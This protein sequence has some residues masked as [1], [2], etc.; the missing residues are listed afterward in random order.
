MGASISAGYGLEDKTR[1]EAAVTPAVTTARLAG[2][3]KGDVGWPDLSAVLLG[4]FSPDP[5]GYKR[6]SSFSPTETLAKKYFNAPTITN[7]AEI[8][9][10]MPYEA[11]AHK[12]LEAAQEGTI[13]GGLGL[14]NELRDA[15][16]LVSIDGFYWPA[17]RQ[18]GVC[19]GVVASLTSLLDYAKNNHKP[20]VL[21]NIPVEDT[22]DVD[23]SFKQAATWSSPDPDCL[24]NLN[25]ALTTH[26]TT[27]HQCY[28]IDM[29]EMMENLKG[30]GVS[31]EGFMNRVRDFRFDG[32]HLSE[33]GT[34]YIADQIEKAMDAHPPDCAGAAAGAPTASSGG[35]STAG[36]ETAGES[37]AYQCALEKPFIMGASIS[38]GYGTE[39]RDRVRDSVVTAA[40]EGLSESPP[41]VNKSDSGFIPLFIKAIRS[42]FPGN[43][44][45]K[46]RAP[47]VRLAENYFDPPD[48]TNIAEILTVLPGGYGSYAYRQFDNALSD[49][50]E[51]G[52]A[53]KLK[54]STLLV[55]LDGFYWPAI[56]E[57]GACPD[58]VAGVKRIITYGHT[59]RKPL[60]LGNVPDEEEASVDAE[61]VETGWAPPGAAC[62]TAINN[63][64][65]ASCTLGNKCYLIDVHGMVEQ[66]KNT[67]AG[68]SFEGATHRVRDFRFDGVHLSAKG[69][70]Y[71]MR[72]ID[73]ALKAHPPDCASSAS[74][75]SSAQF[76]QFCFLFYGLNRPFCFSLSLHF[77]LKEGHKAP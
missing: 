62:L 77:F 55:S 5:A 61:L 70:R 64:L 30:V 8:I 16:L 19:P 23:E 54:G 22:A 56:R 6:G 49:T 40:L 66:L 11:F 50:T 71:F 39:E 69:L 37:T 41:I 48:I 35:S 25:T 1:V 47:T 60:L 68:I 28:L 53:E 12:Q 20:L 24:E 44:L 57:S 59:N 51:G 18:T 13:G 7:I 43:R 73:S 15:T 29:H 67:G 27:A 63:E 74:S 75:V 26:C 52:L 10:S 31:F 2:L 34:R 9:S 21:G 36:G 65:K 32:I 33:R 72:E 46:N 14:S 45:G 17:V 58:V 3:S 38:A 4:A 76:R 42:F